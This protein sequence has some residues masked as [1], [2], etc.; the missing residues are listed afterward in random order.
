MFTRGY[1]EKGARTA[2]WPEELGSYETKDGKTSCYNWVIHLCPK[3][4]VISGIEKHVWEIDMKTMKWKS[5]EVQDSKFH[6]DA[7]DPKVNQSE[8]LAKTCWK[9]FSIGATDTIIEKLQ[10]GKGSKFDIGGEEAE[11]AGVPYGGVWVEGDDEKKGHK[12]AFQKM[13]GEIGASLQAGGKFEVKEGGYSSAGDKV[14]MKAVIKVTNTAGKAIEG[15][16][17]H[18]CETTKVDGLTVMK[19]WS[20]TGVEHHIAAYK[21]A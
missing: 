17:T 21:A 13:M 5:M 6:N 4:E 7:F 12:M 1:D 20:I 15:E 11:K 19:D 18:V 2:P 9:L 3:G 10:M 14:T 8:L 16:E